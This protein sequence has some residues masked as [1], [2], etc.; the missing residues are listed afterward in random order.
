QDEYDEDFI[1]DGF[2]TVTFGDGLPSPGARFVPSPNGKALLLKT[3]PPISELQL[4]KQLGVKHE[5]IWRWHNDGPGIERQWPPNYFNNPLQS[6]MQRVK[7]AHQDGFLAIPYA[8][9]P[10]IHY[11][12]ELA[13][14]FGAEWETIPVNM[15]PYPP[16]AGHHMYR[17]SLAAKGYAD[18]LL[19]GLEDAFDKYQFDGIYTDGMLSVFANS[20]AVAGCGWSDTQGRCHPTWPFFAVRENIKRIYKLV[21]SK[22][23]RI[24]ENHQS[25]SLPAMLIGFSDKL[26]TGELEDFSDLD[27][28]R[29]RFSASPWGVNLQLHRTEEWL[30]LNVMTGL[31]VG[32]Q[33]DGRALGGRHDLARKFM[34]IQ[35]A[36]ETFGTGNAKFLPF[37]IAEPSIIEAMPNN[38]HCAAWVK[39]DAALLV[40]GNY[41]NVPI[42]AE[43][44]LK[45]DFLESARLPQKAS[46]ALT[47]AKYR[48]SAET[49]QVPLLPRNFQMVLIK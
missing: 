19:A 21:K 12:S 29:M 24:V 16:P 41:G 1:P 40:I 33:V 17:V 6:T 5:R 15:I 35:Q 48:Y 46:S 45:K 11:P 18:Y 3:S 9:Y 8:I 26:F 49:L 22:P 10:A 36:M 25:F 31:L 39:K 20:N 23:G 42:N 30:P 7:K 28:A 27:T 2:S 37:H 32:T 34:R 43:I 44:K 13:E 38:V 4:R 47:G 14:Q